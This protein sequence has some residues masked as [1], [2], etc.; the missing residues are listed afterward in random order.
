MEQASDMIAKMYVVRA[1]IHQLRGVWVNINMPDTQ[2]R[3]E[4]LNRAYTIALAWFTS[5]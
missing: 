1:Y 5:M 4:M 2:R 3:I